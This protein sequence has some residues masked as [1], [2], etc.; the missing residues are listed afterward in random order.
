MKK[1]SIFLIALAAIITVGIC[2]YGEVKDKKEVAQYEATYKKQA[3]EENVLQERDDD[4][5][6]ESTD[7]KD[8][9][10][11]KKKEEPKKAKPVKK[12]KKQEKDKKE[13]DKEQ[14]AGYTIKEG[15]DLQVI[16]NK[17]GISTDELM[18]MNQWSSLPIV[19]P[20]QVIQ[21]PANKVGALGGENISQQAPTSNAPVAPAPQN[22][23]T[24]GATQTPAP[25]PTPAPAPVQQPVAP[26]PVSQ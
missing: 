4:K 11:T 19:Q 8:K 2:F 26:T 1:S 22:N 20:G 17:C 9:E 15:D 10:E 5:E 13:E 21:V 23:G 14:T 24:Q 25:T 7:S 18:K 16:A 3:K 12:E 6:K